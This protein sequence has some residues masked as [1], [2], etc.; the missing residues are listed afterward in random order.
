[1][2]AMDPDHAAERNDVGFSAFDGAIGHSLAW[3]PRWTPKQA[4]LGMRLCR[5]Y[6]RQ[7]GPGPWDKKEL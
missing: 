7:L 5:K 1:M 3:Q 4:A 6:R 2:A